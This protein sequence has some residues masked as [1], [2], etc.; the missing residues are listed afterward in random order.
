[1]A[2]GILRAGFPST[3]LFGFGTS[4]IVEFA[5]S[6]SLAA[7]RSPTILDL[8]TNSSGAAFGWGLQLL[9]I[10]M[11]EWSPSRIRALGIGYGALALGVLLAFSWALGSGSKDQGSV[12]RSPFEYA[13]GYGWLDAVP[14]DVT[15]NGVP[16][17]H[18]GTGP[19]V[20]EVTNPFDHWDINVTLHGHD[21]S[22]GP[23]AIVFAHTPRDTLPLIL[24]AQ[25]RDEITLNVATRGVRWG[26]HSPT[27]SHPG[28]AIGSDSACRRI[29]AQSMRGHRT[30]LVSTCGNAGVR[31]EMNVSPLLGWTTVVPL[32]SDQQLL[33]LIGTALWIALL[34]GPMGCWSE[35]HPR[36]G[37]AWISLFISSCIAV[38]RFLGLSPISPCTATFVAASFFACWACRRL[39]R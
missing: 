32:R 1:M 7:G 39:Y 5:Q 38:P 35:S 31:T 9:L 15:I 21:S 11:S 18:G 3:L 33:L 10:R 27:L 29:E 13:P 25:R 6:T 26:L 24:L 36:L 34:T 30:I 8:L 2:I 23:R 22:K 16:I 14:T 12:S 19:I 4:L 37:L 17:A 20:A 28:V